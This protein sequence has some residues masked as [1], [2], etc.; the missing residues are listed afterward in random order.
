MRVSEAA[1]PRCS[2][3][4]ADLRKSEESGCSQGTDGSFQSMASFP[5][6][7]ETLEIFGKYLTPSAAPANNRAD[8]GCCDGWIESRRPF[9]LIITFTELINLNLPP[10]LPTIIAVVFVDREK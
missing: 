6:G 9:F 2:A 5:A 8:V 10:P 7:R 4:N 1:R 3:V